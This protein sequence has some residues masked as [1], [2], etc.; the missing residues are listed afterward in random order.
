[1]KQNQQVPYL[2]PLAMLQKEIRPADTDIYAACLARFDRVAKPL[3]GLG[4]LEPL[5]ARVAAAQHDVLPDVSRKALLVFCADNGVVE[6]GV[7]QCGP[8]VTTAIA[9]MM[10]A[11]RSSVC[12]MARTAGAQ[13]F[14]VDVGMRE[15]VPGLAAHK[16]SCGTE[17]ILHGAA[18]SRETAIAAIELGAAMA[19]ARREEGYCLLATGEAGIGN[20]TTA[21]AMAAV[22][23]EQSVEAVT[24]RGAGL[25]DEGLR[26]KQEVIRGAIAVNRPDASDPLD[27]LSKLGGLD[28]AA[29]T[30]AFL[31]AAAAGLPVVM[32]GVISAVAALCAV[33][34][35]PATRD[36]ILP[37][38]LGAEP[39]AG[40]LCRELGFAPILHAAMRLGE[41]TGAVAL[42]PLLDHAA[43][44]YHQAATFADIAVSQNE[45]YSC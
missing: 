44:V 45:R 19:A 3:G 18:M 35:Q 12:V 11:G 40:L 15:T 6:E 23:L 28:I 30:G 27:V 32:D 17:N 13:V 29:M 38:H 42:F 22:L 2:K 37:S 14:P 41:G 9:R 34:L 5:L 24:G 16:F 26:R 8:E 33:R 4:E 25:S 31:G 20:T 43:A 7:T 39:A 36:Y 1:M 10:A 21:A